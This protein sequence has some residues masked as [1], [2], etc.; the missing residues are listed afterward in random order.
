MI[1]RDLAGL[2]GVET[3]RFNE[4]VKRNSR[5]F[6]VDFMFR[7]SRKEAS[8]RVA[9]C[10]RFNTLKHSTILP[11]A[12]TEQGVA[13]LPSVLKLREILSSNAVLR[14]KIESMER[15][16]DSQFRVIF[17]AIKQLLREE[18]KPK[19]TIGFHV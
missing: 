11:M 9:I 1:D 15:K 16:Y 18:K 6:P 13:M 7:L 12:F 10:D 5:R 17:E 3:K 4:Q 14:N 8:E 2:Y 19:K